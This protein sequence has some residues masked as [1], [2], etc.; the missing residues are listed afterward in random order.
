[1]K[2]TAQMMK[3]IIFAACFLF[4][5]VILTV[6][7]VHAADYTYDE[8]IR[9]S[10]DLRMTGIANGSS[11]ES[12]NPEPGFTGFEDD[13]DCKWLILRIPES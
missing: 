12:L 11:W 6:P 7:A 10:Q 2:R 5:T 3:G 1:M 8:L 9:D 4:A 13:Q